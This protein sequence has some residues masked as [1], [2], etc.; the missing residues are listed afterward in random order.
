MDLIDTLHG[1]VEGSMNAYGL[2]DLA[3]GTVTSAEPL[4]VT[5]REAMAPL[6]QEVLW[7][8]AAVIEKKIP[9]LGHEHI[10]KGFR[11]RHTVSGLGHSHGIS[12]L[13]HAHDA[14]EGTTG[15][16]LNGAYQTGEGLGGEHLTNEA[17]TPDAYTSDKRLEDIVCYED[18]KPLPVKDGYIILNRG[19][20]VGDKVLMLRVMRGQQFII[21]SRIFERGERGGDAAAG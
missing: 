21:L 1:I 5:V 19:L 13:G 11:H 4:E 10:T 9:V 8:T 16:A 12:N 18:G 14:P 7:L 17:L 15:S 6:P 3:V 20:A 2:S